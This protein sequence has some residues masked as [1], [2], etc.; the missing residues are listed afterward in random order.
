[1][2]EE[3]ER[4]KVLNFRLT[5]I[6]NTLNEMK[7]VLVETKLQQR[8]INDLKKLQEEILSAINS[9]DQRIRAL[10]TAPAENKAKWWER[11]GDLIFKGVLSAALVVVLAKI[12]LN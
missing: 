1:M 9:H 10:E 5:N 2:A 3:T 7:N 8:D 6:E 12:G 4:D 11:A